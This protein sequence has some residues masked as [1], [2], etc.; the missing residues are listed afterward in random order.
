MRLKFMR[1]P[2]MAKTL[3]SMVL[4][5][6]SLSVMAQGIQAQQLAL[7]ASS[8]SITIQ[9]AVNGLTQTQY[10][11]LLNQYTQIVNDSKKV[12]DDPASQATAEQQKQAFCARYYAYKNI[13]KI[14]EYNPSLYP[15]PMMLMVA[16]RY[17]EQQHNSFAA[18]GMTEQ[19]FCAGSTSKY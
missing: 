10:Q 7:E 19:V 5:L 12:L 17:L 3:V 14:S 13:A 15:A 6:Q 4:G 9:H 11:D 16:K 8:T 18:S 1:M 2:N